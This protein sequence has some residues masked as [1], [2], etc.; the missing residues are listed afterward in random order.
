MPPFF[1]IITSTYNAASTL[2]RL[3][4]SLVSQTCQDFN[5]IVQDG[6]SS[7][8]TMQIVEQYRN[9]LPEILADTEKDNGIYDAWNKAIEHWQDK[10]GEWVLFLGADDYLSADN[11]L[12]K[13]KERINTLSQSK[14]FFAG[15]IILI[16]KFGVEISENI[17]KD[18]NDAFKRKS[19][20]MPINHPALFTKKNIILKYKFDTSFKISGDYDFIRRAWLAPNQLQ[21]LGFVTTFMQTGGISASEVS[22]KLH[23]TENLRIFNKYGTIKGYIWYLDTSLY[24]IKIKVKKNLKK[25]TLGQYIWDTLKKL[26]KFILK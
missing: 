12:D 10:L 6:A 13:V 11:I 5:W 23:Q 14:L 3:L 26:R 19:Y 18:V 2:P 22:R 25:Y 24:N 4:D 21:L 9:R 7:D 8:N 16:N 17:T 15:N 20:C 1:T